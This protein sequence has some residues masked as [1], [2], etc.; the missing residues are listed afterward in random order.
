[1]FT[2]LKFDNN[3]ILF[4]SRRK[5]YVSLMQWFSNSASA[6]TGEAQGYFRCA[7]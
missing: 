1:M 5:E 7:L 4:L 6:R 2:N 3:T